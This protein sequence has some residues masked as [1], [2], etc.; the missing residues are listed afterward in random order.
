MNIA[1]KGRDVLLFSRNIWIPEGARYCS[2]HLVGRQL[3]A[4]AVDAVKPFAIRHQ[5]L[6]SCN[7]H[8]ILSKYQ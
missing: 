7:V 3:S 4:E 5:E 1:S 6:N 2:G 8:A